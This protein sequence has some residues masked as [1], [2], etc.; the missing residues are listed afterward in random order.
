MR[1][2]QENEIDY[3]PRKPQNRAEFLEYIQ[4]SDAE[5]RCSRLRL[6]SLSLAS[7]RFPRFTE[8]L[9]HLSLTEKSPWKIEMSTRWTLSSKEPSCENIPKI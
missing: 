9:I 2:T 6:K 3:P 7:G 4:Y 8:Y 5:K 1:T